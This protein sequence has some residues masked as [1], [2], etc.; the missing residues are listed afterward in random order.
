MTSLAANG[1]VLGRSLPELFGRARP[2]LE[3]QRDVAAAVQDGQHDEEVALDEGFARQ[4]RAHRHVG[5]EVEIGQRRHEQQRRRHQ[6][7]QSDPVGLRQTR[8]QFH[9]TDPL[10]S[11]R[12]WFSISQLGTG[13]PVHLEGDQRPAADQAAGGR[14]GADAGEVAG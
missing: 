9:G 8:L 1:T 5:E 4:D 7:L 2:L 13:F 12:P 11:N 14:F 3:G 6:R 10:V